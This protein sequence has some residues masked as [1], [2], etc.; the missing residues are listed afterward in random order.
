MLEWYIMCT[1]VLIRPSS[2][3]FLDFLIK[4]ILCGNGTSKIWVMQ[5][6][7]ELHMF[8]DWIVE[9]LQ[10]SLSGKT[11]A[12]IWARIFIPNMHSI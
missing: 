11:K 5:L 10:I 8:L 4:L 1:Y 7:C 12:D 3:A 2:L 9:I 6:T